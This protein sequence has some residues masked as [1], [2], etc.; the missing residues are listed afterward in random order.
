MT[1]TMTT[2]FILCILALCSANTTSFTYKEQN[3]GVI[4]NTHFIVS[5]NHEGYTVSASSTNDKE[6]I[7]QEIVCDSTFATLQWHY[8]SNLSTNISF[9]RFGNRIEVQGIFHGRPEKK[10]LEIEGHPWYQIIPLGL[11]TVLKD[12]SGRSKLWAISLQKPAILKPVCFRITESADGHLP[13]HP[14]IACHYFHVKI[15]GL[16]VRIWFGDY[17]LRQD[18]HAFL[19][20]EGHLFGSKK[21]TETIECVF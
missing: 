10:V 4:C 12:S 5:A 18:N 20:Y 13:G 17:F 19:Y 8:Q 6:Q 14:E 16:S 2:F 15:E 9:Q 3:N 7:R 1:G 11:Q 21:P